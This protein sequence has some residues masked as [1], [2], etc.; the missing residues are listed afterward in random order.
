MAGWLAGWPTHADG[1][2]APVQGC[3]AA[4][5]A[6]LASYEV[7]LLSG[8]VVSRLWRSESEAGKAKAKA[9]GKARQPEQVRYAAP[10][11]GR[12]RRTA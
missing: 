10:V 3:Q 9:K 7:A 11:R 2:L 1:A 4:A 6:S 8:V 5:K 12:G